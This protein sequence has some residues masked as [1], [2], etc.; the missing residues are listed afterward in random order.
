MVNMEVDQCF[1]FISCTSHLPV[2]P[3]R[4]QMCIYIYQYI[5]YVFFFLSFLLKTNKRIAQMDHPPCIVQFGSG[6][7]METKCTCGPTLAG[8]FSSRNLE[9]PFSNRPL[10]VSISG[11]TYWKQILTL[12]YRPIY[13]SCGSEQCTLPTTS[14]H[15]DW[16]LCLLPSFLPSQSPFF[17]A[18][19]AAT[20]VVDVSPVRLKDSCD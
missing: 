3:C 14:Y 2:S 6:G 19:C 11:E 20:S 7:V 13:I 15:S 17:S 10:S 8:H 9:Q 4:E 5:L 1:A 16:C 12:N 18:F